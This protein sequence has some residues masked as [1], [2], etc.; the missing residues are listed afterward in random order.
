MRPF[1]YRCPKTGHHVQGFT[2]EEVSED[3]YEAITCLACGRIHLV[4]STTG[5]VAGDTDE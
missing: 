5:E 3:E 4:S 2:A 1:L